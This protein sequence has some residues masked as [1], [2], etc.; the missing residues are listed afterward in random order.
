MPEEDIFKTEERLKKQADEQKR[1]RQ[2]EID[3]VK[4][5]LKTPAGRR[6]YWRWM[7][8][9]GIFRISFN[10]NSNQTAFNE[11]QRNVGLSLLNDLNEA[12]SAIFA[13]MQLEY[14]S[15]VKNKKEEHDGPSSE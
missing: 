13:K 5:V 12:D 9:C 4:E 2:R 10:P 14:I 15:T 8:I 3:D 1:A 6:F 7:G 11:G